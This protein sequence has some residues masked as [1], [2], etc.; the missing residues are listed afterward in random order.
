[1][2]FYKAVPKRFLKGGSAG[3]FGTW[4][5]IQASGLDPARA[6]CHGGATSSAR[7]VRT[8]TGLDQNYTWLSSSK[9]HARSYAID[10]LRLQDPVVIQVVLPDAWATTGRITDHGAAGWGTRLR[11]PPFFIYFEAGQADNFIPIEAYNGHNA[12]ITMEAESSDDSDN[13]WD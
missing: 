7:Q 13:D 5:G 1:M 11:I 2:Y 8:P 3:I 9:E 12:R 6:G 4:T 10:H